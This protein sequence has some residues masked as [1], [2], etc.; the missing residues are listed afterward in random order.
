MRVQINKVWSAEILR[1][2][3]KTNVFLCNP[4]EVKGQWISIDKYVKL[5]ELVRKYTNIQE[6]LYEDQEDYTVHYLIQKP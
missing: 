2:S 1:P 3:N 4:G 6:V 5:K